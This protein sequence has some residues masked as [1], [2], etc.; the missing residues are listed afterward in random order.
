M[1]KF[2][3]IRLFLMLLLISSLTFN[4]FAL[5]Y[6]SYDQIKMAIYNANYNFDPQIEFT[7]VPQNSKYFMNIDILTTLATL[8]SEYSDYHYWHMDNTNLYL[9]TYTMNGVD[10]YYEIRYNAQYRLTKEMQENLESSIENIIDEII[11][12][13]MSQ[14]EKLMSIYSFVIDWVEYDLSKT[15]FDAYNAFFNHSAVCQGYALLMDLML[16]KVG[17]NSIIIN[18]IADN[19]LHAWNLVNIDGNYY[20]VDATFG[21]SNS[22]ENFNKYFMASSETMLNEGRN[23]SETV[24]DQYSVFKD[25]YDLL[26]F[27]SNGEITREEAINIDEVQSSLDKLEVE[28]YVFDPQSEYLASF[29]QQP[30]QNNIISPDTQNHWARETI[31][32]LNSYSVISD[33]FFDEFNNLRPDSFITR[34]EFSLLVVDALKLGSEKE[35]ENKYFIDIN[36]ESEFFKSTTILKELGIINGF[37]DFTYKP[38]NLLKRDE[39]ATIISN[40]MPNNIAKLSNVTFVDTQSN[41]AYENIEKI[42][43]LGIIKGDNGYYMPN[44]NLTRA[45]AFTIIERILKLNRLINI[46]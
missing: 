2:K 4:S 17:I 29:Y 11:I 9:T 33:Y 30:I 27:N 16:E 19:E 39:I 24:F 41:W 13:S 21:D 45:E 44:K 38:D 5:E 15:K 25:K 12:D 36:Y 46:E 8:G 22:I 31:E 3:L 23:I 6:N 26:V 35:Y 28:K 1:K 37:E 32:R 43:D 34:G 40:F 7:Y 20:H 10:Q 14:K 18:G 42:K